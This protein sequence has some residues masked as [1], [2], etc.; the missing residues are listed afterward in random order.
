[1]G[2]LGDMGCFSLQQSKQITCGDG[3][4]TIINDG[5]LAERARLFADKGWPRGRRDDRGYLFLATNCRMTELQGAVALAQV[6]KAK[7]IVERRRGAGDLLKKLL[8]GVDGVIPPEVPPGSAHFYWFYPLRIDMNALKVS[9]EEFAEAVSA[10]GIPAS[11]GYIKKPLH[12]YKALRDKVTYGS[13][14]CP[15]D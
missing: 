2:T 1:M 5:E 10:E 12:L 9:A 7:S 14:H 4:I 15:F 6:H 3:G 8:G 13:S 11:A